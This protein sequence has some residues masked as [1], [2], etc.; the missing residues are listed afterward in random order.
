VDHAYHTGTGDMAAAIGAPDIRCAQAIPSA[1]SDV[2]SS[3]DAT[4][5]AFGYPIPR[6]RQS[7]TMSSDLSEA[8]PPM[9]K[10]T[11]RTATPG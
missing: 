9:A 6:L 1:N 8:E 10:Q 3:S 11:S 5:G 2:G 7:E 4:N